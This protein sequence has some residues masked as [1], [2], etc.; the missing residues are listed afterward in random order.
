MSLILLIYYFKIQRSFTLVIFALS[1]D[2][3]R[4]KMGTNN[5]F[6]FQSFFF[7]NNK[8][9]W[10]KLRYHESGKCLL[11]GLWTLYMEQ[12]NSLLYCIVIKENV[13]WYIVE[14]PVTN[15]SGWVTYH[16]TNSKVYMFCFQVLVRSD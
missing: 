3:V 16:E 2:S 10:S 1:L 8:N 9:Q 12:V 14:T 11:Q 15:I 4:G 7:V 6:L 13:Y 5:F